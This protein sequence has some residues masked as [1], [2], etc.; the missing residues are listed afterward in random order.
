MP[1]GDEVPF[2][3]NATDSFAEPACDLS[4]VIVS[5]N[6]K[7]LTVECIE[8][9]IRET[10]GAPFTWEI[11][12]V[13]NASNDGSAEAI[14]A[15]F[16]DDER[17]RL[18]ALDENLGF[19]KG[20]NR[21]AEYCRGRRLL[22]LN[23]DTLILDRGIEHAMTCA[24]AN[25]DDIIG[26]RTYFGDGSLNPTSCH[27][28]PTL[29]SMTCKGV[30]LS[31]LFRNSKLFDPESLG[32][33]DRSTERRVP[34]V[35]GCFLLIRRDHWDQLGGFDEAFFMYGE[36]TDLCMRAARMNIGRRITPAARLV[37]YG[38]A[39]DRVKADK[40]VRL[41]SAKT[42]LVRKHWSR[43][44]AW[45]G[46]QMLKLWAMT[47]AAGRGAVGMLRQGDQPNSWAEIWRRRREFS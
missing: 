29:W 7:K 42:A 12:V 38:G 15:A 44:A 27:G 39:A 6:T 31:V 26:G 11:V 19:A 9:V 13:D 4:I 30:G 3:E 23:P 46:V 2:S 36:E 41:F 20:N 17:V 21:A 43:P 40:M 22:L 35:T 14:A 8:S 34:V 24:L 28:W 45:Y 1:R 18:V 32:K 5:F 10:A 37:H 47:R 16:G 25:P 33:W